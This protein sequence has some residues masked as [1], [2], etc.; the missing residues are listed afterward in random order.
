MR[1]CIRRGISV[2]L[3]RR[4]AMAFRSG[5]GQRRSDSRDRGRG[6]EKRSVQSGHEARGAG[7]QLTTY[8]VGALPIINDFLR[9]MKLEELLRQ[10]LPPDDPRVELPTTRALLVLVRNIL[11]SREPIYGVGDWSAHFAPDLL[12]L[13]HNELS[14]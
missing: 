5:N 12:D 11:V 8:Q 13:Y 3:A 9:R 10:Y 7:V 1:V 6:S 14:M 4:C 2:V